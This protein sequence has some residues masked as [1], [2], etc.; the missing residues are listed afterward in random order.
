MFFKSQH[1]LEVTIEL[2]RKTL[3][4]IEK[5]HSWSTGIAVKPDDENLDTEKELRELAYILNE[6][7]TDLL[8]SGN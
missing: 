4:L 1:N 6:F 7:T 2:D 3:R 5:L 8:E